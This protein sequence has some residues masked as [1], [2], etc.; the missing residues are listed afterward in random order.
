M[1]SVE[2]MFALLVAALAVISVSAKLVFKEDGTFKILHVSDVHY[3]MPFDQCADILDSQLPCNHLNSSAFLSWLIDTEK[4]DLVVHTGDII[5]WATYPAS[6]GMS[7]YYNVSFSHGVPWAA[8]LGNHDDDSAS[9]PR[10][11]SVLQYIMS[12]PGTLT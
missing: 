3:E 11:D 12:L 4:P 1:S 5:D 2:E 6:Q 10:R 7:E 9:M 8:S